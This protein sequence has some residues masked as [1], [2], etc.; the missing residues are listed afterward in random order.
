MRRLLGIGA[1]VLGGVGALV[2]VAAIGAGW[3]AASKTAD[4]VTRAATR[5]DQG[6]AEAD[7]ALARTEERLAAIRADIDEV[8]GEADQ[9]V[10]ENPELPRV[11][12]AIERLLDRIKLTSDRAGALADSLRTVSA[13]LRA[14]ADIRDLVAG[15]PRAPDRARV[16]AGAIDRAA[17][18]LN[19]PRARIDAVKSAVAVRLVREL[20]D[21]I[22]EALA[23]SE[24]LASGLADA[25]HEIAAARDWTAESRARVVFWVYASAAVHTLMWVWVGLGQLCLIGW[26]RRISRRGPITPIPGTD[27]PVV[28]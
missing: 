15:Q 20:V 10:A 6:L 26:G 28:S 21:L 23:G 4:G 18:V 19:I 11:R 1:L 14:T 24:R 5:A 22:R 12:A 3:W 27:R 9:L 8:R 13:G 7:A 17:E 2:C 25:R 16:A